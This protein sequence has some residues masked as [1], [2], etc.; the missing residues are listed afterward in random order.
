[1][2]DLSVFTKMILWQRWE[3]SSSTSAFQGFGYPAQIGGRN[4]GLFSGGLAVSM[5]TGP[6][7]FAGAPISKSFRAVDLQPFVG[8]FFSRGNFYFQGFEAIDVP[9]DPNDVTIL[10]NDIGM[11]YYVYRNPDLD[12]FITA[13][14]PTFETHIN[15]P[16]NHRGVYNVNDPI[17]MA[18][19]VDLTLGANVQFGRRTLLL[20]GAVT[21]VSGPRPFAIEATALLNVYFGGRAIPPITP[22]YPMAGQ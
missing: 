3:D 2:G 14:A 6:G 22:A 13:F 15:I 10:F 11:G 8:Y 12:T 4:G 5:P 1:M 16:L 21:P 18:D 19:V 7:A 9:C 17:G 20:L